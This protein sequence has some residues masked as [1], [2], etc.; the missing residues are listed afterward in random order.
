MVWTWVERE[1]IKKRMVRWFGRG[2][3]EVIKKR[4]VRW[5]GRGLREKSLR[6][7]W[8]DGLDVG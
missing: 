8:S 2:L 3:R 5:F 4:M 6:R 1:V 7:G